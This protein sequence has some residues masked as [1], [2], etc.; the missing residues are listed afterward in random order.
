MQ[1]GYRI[2][3]VHDPRKLHVSA[4]EALTRYPVASVL[5]TSHSLAAKMSSQRHDN[6]PW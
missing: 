5:A 6:D 3:S 2:A 1:T 4:P